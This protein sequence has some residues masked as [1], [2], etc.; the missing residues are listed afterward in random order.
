MR[1]VTADLENAYSTSYSSP[2]YTQGTI[3]LAHLTNAHNYSSRNVE[4]Q[5]NLML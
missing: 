4:I 1:L 5:Q 3:G 2:V